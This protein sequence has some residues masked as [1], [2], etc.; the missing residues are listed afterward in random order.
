MNSIAASITP[1]LLKEIGDVE[2]WAHAI[3]GDMSQV[4]A[5]LEEI[6]GPPSSSASISK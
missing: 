2:N 5:T 4:V 6:N 3:E 1:D